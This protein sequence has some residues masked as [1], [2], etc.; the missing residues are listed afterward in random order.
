M[1][2]GNS[3]IGK[4]SNPSKG[5]SE[6]KDGWETF[7]LRL[8]VHSTITK[9]LYVYF[10]SKHQNFFEPRQQF[11]QKHI[12]WFLKSSKKKKNPI[13]MATKFLE[14][15]GAY[16][17]ADNCTW[18]SVEALAQVA[19]SPLTG[20]FSLVENELLIH[21]CRCSKRDFCLVKFLKHPK[22]T[23]RLYKHG[24]FTPT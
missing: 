19:H 14:T 15:S 22:E 18:R 5:F 11:K 9:T 21:S 1:V 16:F 2:L 10:K 13:S 20:A 23:S 6:C 3:L 17:Y 12:K 24:F 7:L 4:E 8:I